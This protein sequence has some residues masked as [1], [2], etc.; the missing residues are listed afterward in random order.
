MVEPRQSRRRFWLKFILLL[1]FLA[2]LIVGLSALTALLVLRQGS[3]VVAENSSLPYVHVESIAPE[4]ALNQLAGDPP[5]ALA[6][7]AANAGELET[8]A[9][10]LAFNNDIAPSAQLALY[11]LLSR[12]AIDAELNDSER[13][14]LVTLLQRRG[15][16][17]AVLAPETDS[18]VQ[19][20]FL[21]Q[22][23]EDLVS[24][25]LTEEARLTASNLQRLAA[26]SPNSLP[27]QRRQMVEPIRPFVEE[28]SAPDLAQKIAEMSRNPFAESEGELL[29]L[30]LANYIRPLSSQRPVDLGDSAD[31]D[32][33]AN[34][35][36]GRQEAARRLTD[37]LRVAIEQDRS[38]RGSP[39]RI[40]SVAE[41]ELAMLADALRLEDA[42]RQQH[43]ANVRSSTDASA[44]TKLVVLL[45]HNWWMRN[46][47]RIAARGYGL[48][49]VPEWE[50]EIDNVIGSSLSALNQEI[51]LAVDQVME[52]L[53]EPQQKAA[54]RVE[55]F[56][57]L[58][59][60]AEL[61]LH[62][63]VEIVQLW[64]DLRFAQDELRNQGLLLA[65]PA[66]WNAGLDKPE[67]QF[68]ER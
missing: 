47:A 63:E 15:R 57:W 6:L 67:F 60:Q 61:D 20:H 9:S 43:V 45:E 64:N 27:A 55:K 46:R 53:P 40:Q 54:L 42:A 25:G 16:A 3:T 4:L 38:L 10:I 18:T 31:N 8:A 13:R 50:S 37:K 65:L 28:L 19:A 32:V 44:E 22:G 14:R 59:L 26:Q 41:P 49:I 7:Q 30:R 58:T 68:Q 2:C 62:P 24:L 29:P 56:L 66:L 48:S 23:V 39:E 51:N 34:A 21:A 52:E 33:V 11:Q 17:L 12:K 35:V 1:C 5:E 36:I